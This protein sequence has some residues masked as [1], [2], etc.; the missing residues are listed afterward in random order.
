MKN[1][2]GISKKAKVESYE[3]KAKRK[4]KAERKEKEKGKESK[5]KLKRGAPN[6]FKKENTKTEIEKE[7]TRIGKK[8]KRKRI[9]VSLSSIRKLVFI[10]KTNF[11]DG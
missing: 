1:K 5:L 2:Q 7:N 10:E 4:E 11:K 6:Y 9:L 8:K 3:E